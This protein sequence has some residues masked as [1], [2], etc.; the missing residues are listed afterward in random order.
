MSRG[1][2]FVPFYNSY[3]ESYTDSFY[4]LRLLGAQTF[5][6]TEWSLTTL[7]GFVQHRNSTSRRDTID[8]LYGIMQKL[9]IDFPLPDYLKSVG[10]IFTEAAKCAIVHD[11]SL[12][13]LIAVTGDESDC[14]SWV[15]DWSKTPASV[16]A[17][18]YKHWKSFRASRESASIFRFLNGDKCLSVCGVIVDTITCC[19]ALAVEYYYEN[20]HMDRYLR[21]FVSDKN[22]SAEII[23][24]MYQ[25]SRKQFQEWIFSASNLSDQS[26][27]MYP[28]GETVMQAFCRT[29]ILDAGNKFSTTSQEN[30]EGGNSETY[31]NPGFEPWL[32]VYLLGTSHEH[33][34]I[35]CTSLERQYPGRLHSI[36]KG[37]RT[38]TDAEVEN[39]VVEI[40]MLDSPRD[41]PLDYSAK[42]LFLSEGTKFFTTSAKHMGKALPSIQEGDVV[43][44]ISG[45]KFPMIARKTGETYQLVSPAYVHGMMYGEKWPD[46]VEDLTDIVLS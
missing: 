21:W 34:K 38:S 1:I 20:D 12:S 7:L 3:I 5:D 16:F 31:S 26:D 37:L 23:R 39:E 4:K 33:V 11:K 29:L 17:I 14:P 6:A 45:V 25:S 27:K 41:S 24:G 9:H 46:N 8:G 40:L 18:S 2:K 15:P 36:I 19:A 35:I 22:H 42:A 10:E 28:N 13:L 43:M 30:S 32:L 44:L